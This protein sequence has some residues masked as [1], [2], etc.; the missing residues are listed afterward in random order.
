VVPPQ[1]PGRRAVGHAVLDDQPDGQLLDSAG[2]VALGFGQVGQV[3]TEARPTHPAAVPGVAQVD[4]D[5]AAGV[6][7]AEVEKVAD[8]RIVPGCRLVAAPRA[9]ASAIHAAT[10]DDSWGWK[11]FRP[12]DPFGGVRNVGTRSDHGGN[13]LRQLI[14]REVRR[15]SPE[16]RFYLPMGS[17]LPQT[18]PLRVTL[19]IPRPLL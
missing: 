1:V 3:G 2:V 9:G 17:D 16:K 10:V 18:R 13:L 12:G 14:C 4:L 19:K 15:T 7:V 8:I 5:R 11:I 6:E